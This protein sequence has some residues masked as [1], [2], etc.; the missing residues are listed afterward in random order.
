MKYEGS[1]HCGNVAF[2]V[3]GDFDTAVDCNCSMC[4]RRGG[5]LAFVPRDKLVLTVPEQNVSTYQFNRHVIRHHFCAVCGIA[6]FGEGADGK[7]NEMAAV[8]LR[9]IPAIDLDKLSITKV[10]GRSF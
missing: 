8:N 1:C 3:E 6:P 5:L 7:G 4:R 9:C 10:D 2:E